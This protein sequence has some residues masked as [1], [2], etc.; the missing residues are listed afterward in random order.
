MRAVYRGW[1]CT[2][3]Q[4]DFSGQFPALVR[5]G[6]CVCGE[7]CMGGGVWVGRCIVGKIFD[8]DQG[9][10]INTLYVYNLLPNMV[11]A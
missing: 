2:F 5:W 10:Q 8:E 6:R 9:H 7:V 3:P 11:G 1:H 4:I